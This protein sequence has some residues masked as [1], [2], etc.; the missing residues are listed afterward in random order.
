MTRDIVTCGLAAIVVCAALA[1]VAAQPQQPPAG[2]QGPSADLLRHAQQRMRDGEEQEAVAL[3]RQAVAA[4]PK[5]YQSNVGLGNLLD[6]AGRYNEARESFA[7]AAEYGPTEENRNRAKRA[8]AI[9]YGFEADCAGATKYEE[10]IYRQYLDARDFYNAGEVANELARLCLDAG[11]IDEAE[12]WYKTGTEAGLREPDIKI[13]RQD[14]WHYR[15]EH[16]LARIAARRGDKAGAEHH[17]AAAKQILDRGN[18]PAQQK[19]FFPYL[20]GYVALYTGDY[21]TALADLQQANQNDAYVLGLIAQTYEK[22]GQRDAALDYYR[23]VMASTA[24]N[25][26]TAGSR[27]LARRKIAELQSR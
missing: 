20:T 16:A 27:P 4:D 5:S 14:L 22:L 23:K 8:I 15:L 11:R 1:D 6:L 7:K 9:S 24:H 17:V 12:R 2:S 3:A 19:E 10:P 13:E 21:Q 25:P 26:T 18:M